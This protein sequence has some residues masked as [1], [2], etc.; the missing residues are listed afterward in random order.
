[1][2]KAMGGAVHYAGQSGNGA[3]LK[4]AVNAMFGIQIAALGELLGFLDKSGVDV[5]AA[6]DILSATPVLSPAAKGAAASMLGQNFAPLF[7]VE[8]IEKDFG[9]AQTTASAFSAKLPLCEQTRRV[10]QDAISNGFG[11]Y[12]ATGVVKLYR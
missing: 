1:V 3:L 8:L 7:P 6:V 2:L 10:F 11:D 12:H 4:L 5:S 9:Y